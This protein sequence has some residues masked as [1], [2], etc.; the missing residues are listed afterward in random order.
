MSASGNDGLRSGETVVRA[1]RGWIGTPYH[2][3]A[4]VKGVG[5]DCLGL[6][7]GVWREIHGCEAEMP[8]AYSRD[9]A[10]ADGRETMIEAAR[11]H[12]VEIEPDAAG[13][14]DVLV[15]R[16]RPGTVAKHAGVVVT[17]AT[18]IHAMEG[19]PVAEVPLGPWWRRRIAA[20]FSFPGGE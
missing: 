16:L 9:W 19:R 3:Q 10:E 17:A 11:R 2:H 18:M 15:F 6:V 20:A 1:V 8:P 7:R 5:T 4:S 13:P 12:L 14:G